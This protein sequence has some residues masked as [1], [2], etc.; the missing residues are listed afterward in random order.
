L[1]AVAPE[2]L[3]GADE[4]D[5]TEALAMVMFFDLHRLECKSKMSKPPSP[6]DAVL[7]LPFVLFCRK[8]MED[9]DIPL[10]EPTPT[11]S[12]FSTSP[13]I[14]N[15]RWLWY[16]DAC[17]LRPGGAHDE[18]DPVPVLDAEPIAEGNS[19]SHSPVSSEKDHTS[20]SWDTMG[21][22]PSAAAPPLVGDG[23]SPTNRSS[24]PA[25]D[26]NPPY[27]IMAA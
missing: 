13:P 25:D 6:D 8:P 16:T 2:L 26:E 4:D 7:L 14:T 1:P 5:V 20:C 18:D 12:D 10:G 15:M 9:P 23:S 3:A 11:P 24:S 19:F 21:L 17:P 27:T 22:L